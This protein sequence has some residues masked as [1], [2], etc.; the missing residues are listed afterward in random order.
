M[1]CCFPTLSQIARKDGAP[2]FVLHGVKAWPCLRKAEDAPAVR[3]LRLRYAS[4]RMATVLGDVLLF[5]PVAIARQDGAPVFVLLG[6]KVGLACARQKPHLRCGSF[7][8]ATPRS[9]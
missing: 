2:I 7:G 5:K 8:C 6:V 1:G 9:G 4:L 3:V